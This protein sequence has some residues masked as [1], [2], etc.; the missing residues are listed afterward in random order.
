MSTIREVAALAGVSIATVSRVINNDTTYKMTDETRDRVWRAVVELNYKPTASRRKS[1]HPAEPTSAVR[2]IGCVIKLRGGKYSDPY[3]LSLLSGMENYLTAHHAEVAFVRTWNELDNSEVLLRTFSERLDG[4]IVMSH[5]GYATFRYAMSKV[6]YM[7]GIDTGFS[8]IDNIEYDHAQAVQTAI[9]YL[10][11]KGYR[12]IGFI[13]GPEGETPM[14]GCRRFHSYMCAMNDLGLSIRNECVLDCGWNDGS[15]RR[16]L[17]ELG[18]EKM[19][20][21]FFVS[22]DLMALAALRALE[23]MQIAVPQ[24]VAVMGLTNLEMSRY[25]N[26]PLTTLDIPTEEMGAYAA[27]MLLQRLDGE[28]SLPRRILFP[29][30]LVPRESA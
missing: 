24:Q 18:R 10:Y 23:E 14:R 5:V 22:S 28:D 1:A 12:D 27:K 8:E 21:A 16:L 30:R 29:A 13:G 20:R 9:R 6:P 25:S 4:L 11:E 17:R 26:P 3:Y 19:P 2:R 15:C 7:V